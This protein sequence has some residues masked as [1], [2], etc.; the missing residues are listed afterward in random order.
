MIRFWYFAELCLWLLGVVGGLGWTLYEGAYL[1]ALG[2]LALGA[3]SIPYIKEV[4]YK[5]TGWDE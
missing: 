1:I 3:Y 5:L 4:Y 2:V